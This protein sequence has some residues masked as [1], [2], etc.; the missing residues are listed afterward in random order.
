MR[1]QRAPSAAQQPALP[2]GGLDLVP[3]AAWFS[4]HVEL[5][6][7]D[8][9]SR[10]GDEGQAAGEVIARLVAA[11]REQGVI[12]DDSSLQL[13]K[14]LTVHARLA[15]AVNQSAYALSAALSS[16]SRMLP[17]SSPRTLTV[18]LSESLVQTVGDWGWGGA[19]VATLGPVVPT[20]VPVPGGLGIAQRSVVRLGLAV[21][22]GSGAVVRALDA[23]ARSIGC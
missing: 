15:T 19:G 7:T 1:V 2:P 23:V 20:L 9:L 22:T 3:A 14:E 18:V 12:D 13:V 5:D 4:A 11:C 10:V 6:L 8:L 21:P 16:A 17:A